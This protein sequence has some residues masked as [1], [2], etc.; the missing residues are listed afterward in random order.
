MHWLSRS[1]TPRTFDREVG[2]LQS[3]LIG[4][5]AILSYVRYNVDLRVEEVKRLDP[6]LKDEAIESLSAMDAPQ[7]MDTLHRLGELAAGR[8][9]QSAHFPAAF[10]LS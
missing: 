1:P 4:G 10:D 7:N 8:D 3:D 2:A 9:I 5:A 6:S